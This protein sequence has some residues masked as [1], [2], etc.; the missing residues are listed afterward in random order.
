M[1]S[2]GGN[3]GPTC[4]VKDI[5]DPQ[6]CPLNPQMTGLI[7]NPLFFLRGILFLVRQFRRH[8]ERQR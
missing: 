7:K 6:K 5:R 3:G 8:H 2:A 4:F 1:V